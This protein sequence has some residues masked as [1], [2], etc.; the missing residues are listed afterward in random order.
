MFLFFE[1]AIFI[2]KHLISIPFLQNYK[3]GDEHM[4]LKNVVEQRLKI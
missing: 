4:L 3:L 2:G 1:R